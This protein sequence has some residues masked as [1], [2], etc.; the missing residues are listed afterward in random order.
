MDQDFSWQCL[1]Q[2]RKGDI[3][4]EMVV[5]LVNDLHFQLRKKGA[6]LMLTME[7]KGTIVKNII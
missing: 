3:W 4:E 7:I 1:L 2:E 6:G 5:Q